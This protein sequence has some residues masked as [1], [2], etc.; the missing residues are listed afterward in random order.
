MIEL[1][2]TAT[3][4]GFLGFF[5]SLFPRT[6]PFAMMVLLA[7]ASEISGWVLHTSANTAHANHRPLRQKEGL[8]VQ[9]AVSK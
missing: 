5:V 8:Y 1:T 6:W 7:T 3:C 4:F 9:A 2:G